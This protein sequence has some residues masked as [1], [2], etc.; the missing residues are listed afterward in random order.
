MNAMAAP[1]EVVGTVAAQSIGE[2]TTQV[3]SAAW[4]PGC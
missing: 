4:V 3:S 1:G 2:P